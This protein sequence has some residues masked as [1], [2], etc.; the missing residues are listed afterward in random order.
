MSEHQNFLAENGYE[1]SAGYGTAVS[2][3]EFD[4]ATFTTFSDFSVRRRFPLYNVLTGKTEDLWLT[5]EQ[6]KNLQ[7]RLLQI[8]NEG[9]PHPRLFKL[10]EIGVPDRETYSRAINAGNHVQGHTGSHMTISS[11]MDLGGHWWCGNPT[12]FTTHPYFIPKEGKGGA[13]NSAY[14]VG[15]ILFT[16]PDLGY[17]GADDGEIWQRG[18]HRR[19]MQ[20]RVTLCTRRVAKVIEEAGVFGQYFPVG[21]A[22]TDVNVAR[23][24]V[25]E[26]ATYYC[27]DVQKVRDELEAVKSERDALQKEAATFGNTLMVNQRALD[28]AVEE[29]A[30][31]EKR[32]TELET[33]VTDLLKQRTQPRRF[34]PLWGDEE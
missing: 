30:A 5:A 17:L 29:A 10:H 23:T 15:S 4:G 6:V 33:Q 13:Y 28:L 7:N 3:G 12:R 18:G 21:A 34:N 25:R 9:Q 11:V 19:D 24:E 22:R 2:T 27:A 14:D 32:V 20:V 8:Q 16:T 31:M 1:V 26:F